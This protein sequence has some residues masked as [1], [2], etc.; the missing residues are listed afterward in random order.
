M[1]EELEKFKSLYGGFI[2]PCSQ[3]I[4]TYRKDKRFYGRLHCKKHGDYDIR[5]DDLKNRGCKNCNREKIKSEYDSNWKKECTVIHNNKFDYSNTEVGDVLEHSEIRCRDCNT[6]FKQTPASHKSGR[7]CPVCVLGVRGKSNLK[8]IEDVEKR[9]KEIG[10]NYDF[11][12]SVYITCKDDIE[13]VC[14]KGHIFF[15]SPDELLNAK[16]GCKGCSKS[17]QT[18][19]GE[20]E[21]F[22]FISQFYKCEEN[23][24]KILGGKELDIYVPSIKVGV[25]Y[26]GLYWHSND[27]LKLSH[28]DKLNLAASKDIHLIFIYENDWVDK[29]EVVKR[30]L[31]DNL[32]IKDVNFTDVHYKDLSI[33]VDNSPKIEKL[34]NQNSL[35][36]FLRFDGC[37][38]MK[39]GE[40]IV[41][42]ASYREYKS[43]ILITEIV[44]PL[45]SI[46]T[47]YYDN[48]IKFFQNERKTFK[49]VASLDWLDDL[50]LR[51]LKAEFDSLVK[52]IDYYVEKGLLKKVKTKENAK[53]LTKAG[54]AIYK[55]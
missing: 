32:K 31:K 18:S 44:R 13:I 10:F 16:H 21:L 49:I 4:A 46:Q 28:F 12:K 47:D 36:P 50:F 26:N 8:T 20:K 33:Y 2:P 25:E 9:A 22:N 34:F 51:R 15:Q 37:Y 11:S 7:G 55:L 48:F 35:E 19:K 38:V 45:N 24:R 23:N 3:L 6:T 39:L 14:D 52:N 29:K 54:Y 42:L 17:K 40:D 43:G 41:A 30:K 27:R 53:T 5:G 1:D